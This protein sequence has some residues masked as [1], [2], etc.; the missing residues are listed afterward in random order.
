MGMGIAT[1]VTDQCGIAGYVKNGEDAVVVKAGNT[2]TLRK[3]IESLREAPL[4]TAIA[5]QGKAYART[6]FS[7]PAMLDRYEKLLGKS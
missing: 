2:A 6:H 3:G 5:A 4:R 7:L 1:I